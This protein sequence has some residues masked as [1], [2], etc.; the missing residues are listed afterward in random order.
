MLFG[1][2]LDKWSTIVFTFTSYCKIQYSFEQ[3][4]VCLLLW[5]WQIT[6]DQISPPLSPSLISK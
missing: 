5:L 3:C 6:L 2:I 1:A 4:L